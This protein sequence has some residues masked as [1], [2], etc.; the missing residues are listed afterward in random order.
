MPIKNYQVIQESCIDRQ[1]NAWL[2]LG[3]ESETMV[4]DTDFFGS[5]AGQGFQITK[6]PAVSYFSQI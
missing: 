4:C 2:T 6:W 3:S 1:S 5:T